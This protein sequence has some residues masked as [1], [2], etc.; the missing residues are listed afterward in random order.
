MPDLLR[1]EVHATTREEEAIVSVRIDGRQVA[2]IA[3]LSDT[4]TDAMTSA[5]ASAIAAIAKEEVR[6]A[7]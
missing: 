6:R 7:G 4:P 3:H 5:L 2:Q 1:I